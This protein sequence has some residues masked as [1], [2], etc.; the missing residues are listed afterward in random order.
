MKRLPDVA[1]QA[2]RLPAKGLLVF[3]WL[4]LAWVVVLAATGSAGQYRPVLT[5]VA[6]GT[7]VAWTIWVTPRQTLTGPELVADLGIAAGLLVVAG[8]AARPGRLDAGPSL[9]TYYPV[10]AVTAWAL[11]RGPWGGLFA[12]AVL[13]VAMA[14]ARYVNDSSFALL[15]GH[16]V[17]AL[18]NSS[19]GY[20]LAGGVIG[21]F[22]LLVD[23]MLEAVEEAMN[24][25]LREQSQLSRLRERESLARQI[26]DS[27]LQA[28][29]LVHKR[30]RELAA[31]GAPSSHDVAE[32]AELARTQ[33]LSLRSV[34]LKA[35]ER[36]PPG[37]ASLK[38]ALDPAVGAVVGPA[39]DL[40]VVGT[41]LLRRRQ[42]EEI[43]A[44]VR[45]ALANVVRHAEAT[46]VAVFAEQED[47]M[48]VVSV[49]DDGKGFVLDEA[50]LRTANKAGVL[51]SMKGRIQDLGGTIHI[52]SSPGKGTEVEFRIPVD[53]EP[54]R[55][56]P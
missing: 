53:A 51:S 7:V 27:V 3:R 15:E 13:T 33:E 36:H 16:H 48:L 44:A 1:E 11:A 29:A 54:M 23:R 37:L 40:S 38:E 6:V 25:A 30:G 32:L 17:A 47:G 8:L 28:L 26:H 24:Q 19:I 55:S 9:A 43:A 10:A 35:P 50:A 42:A 2:R 52:T 49:R 46:R 18:A 12:G 5:W 56:Q 20:L 34:I 22:S 31:S 4:S 21:G 41:I 45:E 39:V 14:V